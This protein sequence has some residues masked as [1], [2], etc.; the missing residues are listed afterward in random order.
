MIS[1]SVRFVG[2]VVKTFSIKLSGILVLVQFEKLLI[3]A[4]A[5]ARRGHD[6][7]GF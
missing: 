5:L 3:H 2:L 7:L 1:A 6:S 4:G